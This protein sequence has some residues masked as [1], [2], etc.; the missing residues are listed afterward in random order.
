MISPLQK[1][2]RAGA[3]YVRFPDIQAQLLALDQ[4]S[5]QEL[6]ARCQIP[7]KQPGSVPSECVLTFVRREW[8]AQNQALYEPLLAVL[9]ERLRRRLPRAV[10]RDG[11]TESMARSNAAEQVQ[12]TFIGMLIGEVNGYDERLDFYEIS[13]SQSLAK[14]CLTAKSKAGRSAKRQEELY[15]EEKGEIRADVEEAVG[16][17]D[18]FDPDLLQQ[19]DY[20]SRLP[21]AMEQL[22]PLEKRI[23][24]MWRNDFPIDS[25]DPDVIT[26]VGMTGRSERGIR[27]IRDRAFAKLRGLLTHGDDA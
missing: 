5:P 6:I 4:L 12:D 13:F 23:V 3:L 9:L 20:R 11:K 10:S 24:E 22:K 16:T 26:M 15:D 1:K 7:E 2:T 18:P 8:V 19:E 17:F 14:L 25:K 21:A 27:I